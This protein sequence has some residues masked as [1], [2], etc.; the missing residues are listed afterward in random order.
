MAAGQECSPGF[1]LYIRIV[2]S[3]IVPF[4][5]EFLQVSRFLT[6]DAFND[7]DLKMKTGQ[8]HP[9]VPSKKFY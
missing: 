8:R 5:T 9:Y 7:E 6:K 4:Y 3:P 2:C 1:K